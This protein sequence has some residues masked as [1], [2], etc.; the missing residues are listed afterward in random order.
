MDCLPADVVLAIFAHLDARDVCTLACVS[1]GLRRSVASASLSFTAASTAHIQFMKLELNRG[2]A[3]NA[4]EAFLERNASRVRSKVIPAYAW[5]EQHYGKDINFLHGATGLQSLHLNLRHPDVL[6]ERGVLPQSLTSL[7]YMGW[8][9][10]RSRSER[11]RYDFSWVPFTGLT[12]LRELHMHSSVEAGRFKLD[13]QMSS[14]FS[15][16]LDLRICLDANCPKPCIYLRTG[17]CFPNLTCLHL[18][19]VEFDHV[20]KLKHMDWDA[21]LPNL[22]SLHLKTLEMFS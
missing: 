17:L 2:A 1:Q 10:T 22:L 16:L 14:C 20:S 4:L 13:A 12:S 7:T 15:R 9:R 21:A 5:D 19:N 3:Q 8:S 18:W 11:K 6:E